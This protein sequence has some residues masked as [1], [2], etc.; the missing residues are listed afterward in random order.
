M[1]SIG[2]MIL[3]ALIGNGTVYAEQP[4]NLTT[5]PSRDDR[6]G[7]VLLQLAQNFKGNQGVQ[8]TDC[9]RIDKDSFGTKTWKGEVRFQKPNRFYLYLQQQEDKRFFECLVST[10]NELYEFR[11]QFKKVVIHEMPPNGFGTRSGDLLTSMFGTTIDFRKR[12]DINLR[13]DVSSA[14]PHYI[15]IDLKPRSETDQRDFNRAEIVL[16]A[17][18]MLPMRVWFE[19]PAG[20]EVTLQL[21]NMVVNPNFNASAFAAPRIPEGWEVVQERLPQQS[22]T[23][24]DGNPRVIRQ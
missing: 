12:F 4:A 10:G 17:R 20:S 5:P 9:T 8:V 6:L 22:P 16:S 1:R 14:N 2:W 18:T 24:N 3:G 23:P 19:R 11:P 7:S 21:G 15:Y 13:K